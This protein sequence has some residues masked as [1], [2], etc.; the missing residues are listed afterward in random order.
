MIAEMETGEGKTLTATLPA[1]TA[2]LAGIPVHV[3]TV[4][5][6]LVARDAEWMG[7]IYQALGLTVGTIT[8]GMDL[9]QRRAAYACDITYCTNKQ[10]VFDYLKDRLLLGPENRRLHLQLEGLYR[11]Q[12][13]T[14]KLLMR[15]LCFAIVDEAD[16]VLIDEAR[17][18]L[19][20]SNKGDSV[21]EATTYQQAVEIARELD[22]PRDFT[23]R[24]RDKHI[25]L[26]DF[27]TRADSRRRARVLA[28]SG[29][30]RRAARNWC[31]RR[32][33]RCICT[34]RTSTICCRTARC[35]SST[36]TPGA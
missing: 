20:I 27:G 7:P 29:P 23:I 19:I 8:E 18:P 13:R 3:V 14:S 10:L 9:D 32:S 21:Q 36:S 33:P 4:N 24:A 2:A 17:T 35:R 5:D 30:A 34:R 25:E 16:S 28:A 31:A 6:F 22:T 12:P 26:T 11:E 1:A 15:G